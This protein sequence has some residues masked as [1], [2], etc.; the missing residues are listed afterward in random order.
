MRVYFVIN[1]NCMRWENNRSHLVPDLHERQYKM[2]ECALAF[3]MEAE[4]GVHIDT[5][6]S[7]AT[8]C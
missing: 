1:M 6:H 5:A 8:S 3:L 7:N 4:N 2:R